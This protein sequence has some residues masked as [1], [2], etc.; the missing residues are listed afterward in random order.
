[1][2]I[3]LRVLD[4]IEER[5]RKFFADV[6][7]YDLESRNKKFRKDI[8]EYWEAKDIDSI[9]TMLGMAS[10]NNAM[11]F[12]ADNFPNLIEM[13]K[14]ESALLDAFTGVRNNLHN[15][16]K[17]VIDYL[18]DVADSERMR[19]AGDKIPDKN[20]FILYRGVAGNGDARRVKG[21]SWTDSVNVA[22]FF[23]MRFHLN[24]PTV[25]KIT[26]PNNVILARFADRSESEYIL[27]WPLF[28]KP[29]RIPKDQMVAA[30]KAYKKDRESK[31]D[32]LKL[33]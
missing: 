6:E 25:F 22:A 4:E 3:N 16:S 12:I 32:S 9:L 31:K 29:K 23:A 2:D 28:G 14:Y 30:Y 15:W 8:I 21:R 10:G 7:G 20:S 17:D 5:D 11:S 33:T 24:D 27:K 18:F 13:G 19:A 1:M 26:V